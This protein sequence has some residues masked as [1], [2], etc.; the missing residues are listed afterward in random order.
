MRLSTFAVFVL[1]IIMGSQCPGQSVEDRRGHILEAETLSGT[2]RGED[3]SPIQGVVVKELDMRTKATLSSVTT[4]S[5][6]VFTL[7]EV[8]SS[9][10]HMLV[11]IAPGMKSRLVP[12]RL[13]KRA[14]AVEIVLSK[15]SDSH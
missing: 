13:V 7:P 12:V 11:L 14:R 8:S 15:D 3:H 2:V 10:L 9:S 4:S 5:L 6:G 1:A